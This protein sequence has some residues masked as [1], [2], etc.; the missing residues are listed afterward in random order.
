MISLF[1]KI[2]LLIGTCMLT[3]CMTIKVKKLNPTP[4]V[5][6][7]PFDKT[8]SLKIEDSVLNKFEVKDGKHSTTFT[9][10]DWRASLESGFIN[11]FAKSHKIEKPSD[12]EIVIEEASLSFVM[13]NPHMVSS[14]GIVA[15]STTAIEAFPVLKY[16]VSL[17]D[18]DGKI[19]DRLTETIRSPDAITESSDAGR[20]LEQLISELYEHVAKEFFGKNSQFK[21]LKK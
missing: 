11:S 13:K 19:I 21:N 2:F 20:V 12:L 1:S 15:Y 5:N 3:S 10:E 6:L 16:S 17:H 4:N 8:L 14:F 18:H 9:V 7:I